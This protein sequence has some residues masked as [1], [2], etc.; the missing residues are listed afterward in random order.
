M[1]PRMRKRP[2]LATAAA[3]AALAAATALAQ[4]P[5]PPPSVVAGVPVN[6]DEEKVGSY[7]LPDP[8]V[9]RDGTPVKDAKTWQQRRRPELL[10]L[11]A[12]NQ[13]GKSPGRPKEMSFRV[14]DKGTLALDGKA[15][16]RQVTVHFSAD[17]TGPR[18]ELLIYLPA[19][20]KKPVPLLLNLSFGA[21]SNSVDD[22]GVRPGY[23]WTREKARVPA[24][25]VQS[26]GARLDVVPFLNKGI[27]FATVYYGDIDP[28]FE[29]GIS[30]GVRRLY[31]KGMEDE[32]A[33]DEWGAISAW[34]WGLQRALDY[35]ETDK[36]VDA[37]R[38]GVIGVSRL[39]KTAL[40]AGA[41][42]TRIALV[43]SSCSGEG[44]AS[45]SRRNYGETV[46]HLCARFGY[47][48][49]RYYQ[50]FAD[51]ASKYSSP[52]VR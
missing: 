46:K 30:R 39:G 24:S 26:L 44:G 48:F 1:I 5:A 8:R 19:Q 25:S 50:N 41:T 36:G 51:D 33:A 4:S 14:F 18:M 35:F 43:I 28:D 47:W 3:A 7:T 32:R 13:F 20:A 42:D 11:F 23:V 40:W 16:R 29:G 52:E 38:V 27:G 45:L 31:S 10:Q 34:A 49:C 17:L 37:K 22:P 2:P 21:N 12:D 15:L 6:Y 9:L